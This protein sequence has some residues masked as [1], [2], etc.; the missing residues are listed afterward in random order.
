M[1]LDCNK[2][3]EHCLAGKQKHHELQRLKK[4]LRQSK[5]K[6]YNSLYS[7]LQQRKGNSSNK[8]NKCKKYK[9]VMNLPKN[10]PPFF[11]RVCV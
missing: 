4:H 5:I 1:I 10:T 9:S 11:S 3:K 8:K 2:N 7:L 6:Q